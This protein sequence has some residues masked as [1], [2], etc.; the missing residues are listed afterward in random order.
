[1]TGPVWHHSSDHEA[2][3]QGDTEPDSLIIFPD[4]QVYSSSILF[5]TAQ[6]LAWQSQKLKMEDLFHSLYK[7]K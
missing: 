3:T 4:V 7:N 5:P 2:E 6:S 1:M